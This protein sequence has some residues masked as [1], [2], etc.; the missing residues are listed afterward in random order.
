M[1]TTNAAPPPP[2]NTPIPI[3]FRR[4]GSKKPK[5]SDYIFAVNFLICRH[6]IK[7]NSQVDVIYETNEIPKILL[8][9]E[10]QI[11]RTG[12][13]INQHQTATAKPSANG[14]K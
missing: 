4:H 8:S 12:L 14:D 5:N 2:E 3:N 9:S 10:R 13:F 6:A 1:A 11:R 7:R